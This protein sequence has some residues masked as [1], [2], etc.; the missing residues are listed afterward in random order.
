MSNEL[1]CKLA[2]RDEDPD[3]TKPEA[4]F[5]AASEDVAAVYRELLRTYTPK[6]VG[7]YECSAG[8]VLS[9]Q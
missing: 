3:F 7:I 8:G 1:R 9:G 2:R 5:P 4:V 6:Q